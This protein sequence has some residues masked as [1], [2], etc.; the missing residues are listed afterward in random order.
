MLGGTVRLVFLEW[1]REGRPLRRCWRFERDEEEGLP[2]DFAWDLAVYR[3]LVFSNSDTFCASRRRAVR[4]KKNTAPERE[5]EL[6]R[7]PFARIV[8]SLL[9]L[10][11]IARCL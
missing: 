7:I 11:H 8:E 3:Y 6:S 5:R 10:T 2:L 1:W 9:S 4:V